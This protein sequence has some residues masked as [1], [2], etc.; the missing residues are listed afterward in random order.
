MKTRILLLAITIVFAT[1]GCRKHDE[2]GPCKKKKQP[3]PNNAPTTYVI[4][5]DN[6]HTA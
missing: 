4:H 3:K 1:V 6:T 2:D 5:L